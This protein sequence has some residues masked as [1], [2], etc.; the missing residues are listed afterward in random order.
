MITTYLTAEEVWPTGGTPL[1]KE[2]RSPYFLPVTEEI[3]AEIVRRIVEKLA[4]D[5]RDVHADKTEVA[6]LHEVGVLFSRVAFAQPVAVVEA[7][8]LVTESQHHVHVA[9][10]PEELG[11]DRIRRYGDVLLREQIE[12]PRRHRHPA[13]AE[14]GAVRGD[15]AAGWRRG[16]RCSASDG[17]RGSRR[18]LSACL[19]GVTEQQGKNNETA[20]GAAKVG[21][22]AA[23]YPKAMLS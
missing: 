19:R 14:G 2:V 18:N 17:W 12:E 6:R 15:L 13:R 1:F 23:L 10:A 7:V 3:L 21:H 9:F 22:G 5:E 11:A 8:L 20:R 4:P 16:H